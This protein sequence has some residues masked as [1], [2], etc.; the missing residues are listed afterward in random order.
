MSDIFIHGFETDLKGRDWCIYSPLGGAQYTVNKE[1][2]NVLSAVVPLEGR[3]AVNPA[4]K[5][6]HIRWDIIR[7]R[8]EA[9]KAGQDPD[10]AGTPLS[11][12]NGVS[13]AVA[14]V[15]RSHG[16]HTVEEVSKLTD[17]HINRFKVHGIRELI[18]SAKRFEQAAD[19]RSFAE[20]MERKDAEIANLTAQMAE[21]MQMVKEAQSGRPE[22]KRRDRRP[23][24]AA[25][26]EG[27]VA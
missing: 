20:A 18:E 24:L 4:V 12:W 26:R 7:P 10:I 8:Y 21:L 2:I 1:A 3:G 13:Q 11:A 6:A 15:L 16:I 9:W 14:N 27:A 25:E 17:A 19:N 5:M 22:P 23:K